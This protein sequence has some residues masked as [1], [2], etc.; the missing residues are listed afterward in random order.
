MVDYIDKKRDMIVEFKG[1]NKNAVINDNEFS[2]MQNMVSNN[3]PLLTSGCSWNETDTTGYARIFADNI[4]GKMLGIGGPVG[5]Y[6][7]S[8]YYDNAFQDFFNGGFDSIVQLGSVIYVFP[9]CVAFD[10]NGIIALKSL[11]AEWRNYPIPGESFDTETVSYELCDRNGNGFTY[12]INNGEPFFV[13]FG[14]Q[15]YDYLLDTSTYPY[16]LK[17]PDYS[18]YTFDLIDTTYIKITIP[19]RWHSLNVGD[20]ITI[21][22]GAIPLLTNKPK[23][24]TAVGT[25]HIVVESD[26]DFTTEIMDDEHITITR[27]IPY[28]EYVVAH[29]NR[30]WGCSTDGR[31]I[32][33]CNLGNPYVW[34][35][36]SLTSMSSYAATIGTGGA[37]TGAISY[38]DY[39]WFFKE[40]RVYKVYARNFPAV[41]ITEQPI[42]GVESG[43]G[44]SLVVL[45]GVLYYKSPSAIMALSPDGI[46]RVSGAFGNEFGKYKNAE[47]GELNGKYYICLENTEVTS[48]N[49][50]YEFFVFDTK[51]GLWHKENT[52]SQDAKISSFTKLKNTLYCLRGFD[53]LSLSQNPSVTATHQA[54]TYPSDNLWY[55]ETGDWGIYLPDNK[56]ISKITIKL[57]CDDKVNVQIQYNGDGQWHKLKTIHKTKLSTE[58][59]TLNSKRYDFCRIKIS[60]NGN[61]KIYSIIRTI[62]QGS[63]VYVT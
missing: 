47:A 26:I 23:V 24:I 37:F 15:L 31:E 38:N 40:D 46:R 12:M 44:N 60:G 48:V 1:I 21:T 3:Y 59:I 20:T 14:Y 61:C 62:E 33:A 22:G 4:N 32:Y 55:A 49:E 39:I 42:E 54:Y 52:A 17:K 11:T 28:M 56:Y 30:L 13:D 29:K 63:D 51:K 41:Q 7:H 10:T 2:D 50:K 57:S 53:A 34:N 9:A 35:D 19:N 6:E 16:S 25:T 5:A 58:T 18:N 8:I 43:S 27:D 45:D 36:F